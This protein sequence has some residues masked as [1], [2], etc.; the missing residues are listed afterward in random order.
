M[1]VCAGIELDVDDVRGPE[2]FGEPYIL[3]PIAVAESLDHR[4]M[5]F[6]KV[7]AVLHDVVEDTDV[8]LE[9]LETVGIDPR[10]VDI[11][12]ILTRR[13]GEVYFDYVSR[14]ADSGNGNA[15]AVKIADVKHNLSRPYPGDGSMKKRYAKTLTILNDVFKL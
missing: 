10:A 11:V 13:E 1:P 15:I 14:I 5:E 7:A 8:T 4:T 6:I 3:H 12:D 2:F 9:D